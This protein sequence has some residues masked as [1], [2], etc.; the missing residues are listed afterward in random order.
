KP[1]QELKGFYKTKPLK[2]GEEEEVEIKVPIKYLAS[3]DG[4]KWVIERG[5][6]EIRVGASSRDIRLRTSITI[7]KDVCFDKHWY[8]VEC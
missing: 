3:Y 5:E 2:P 4:N 8:R 6:Y 1:Y 7:E